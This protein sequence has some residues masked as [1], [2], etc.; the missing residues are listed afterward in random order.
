MN[1]SA[2]NL[3]RK[4]RTPVQRRQVVVSPLKP[5][6]AVRT[7][8]QESVV[9]LLVVSGVFLVAALSSYLAHHNHGALEPGSTN[10]TS[11]NIMGR[12]GAV[13]AERLILLLGWCSFVTVFWAFFL[14]RTIWVQ[15]WPVISRSLISVLVSSVGS[16]LVVI[17]SAV[18]VSVPFGHSGGGRL[19]SHIAYFLI[20]YVNEAG[21][22]LFSLA[23]LL[24]SL[25][26]STGVGSSR[27]AGVTTW[28]VGW[29]RVLV[30]DSVYLFFHLFSVTRRVTWNVCQR[31]IHGIMSFLRLIFQ[32]VFLLV[33]APVR[34]GRKI[35]Y[36]DTSLDQEDEVETDNDL[37]LPLFKRTQNGKEADQGKTFI[38]GEA[39]FASAPE[40][41][42]REEEIDEKINPEGSSEALKIVR[43]QN[44]TEERESKT[45]K[46]L[47]GLG[48]KKLNESYDPN[49][50]QKREAQLSFDAHSKLP[51]KNRI[52]ADKLPIRDFK[53]PPL[54][55]LVSGKSG[56]AVR[57]Q[58]AELV[59]NCRRLERTLLDFRI[60]GKVVEVHPGPVITLY[61]FEP[62]AG[63]KV[64][65]IVSLADDLALALKV[66]SVR[67]YAPV[68]G[69]GTVGIEV[70]NVHRE[71]VRLHDILDSKEFKE[72]E[73][74][75]MLALGKD[76]FGDPYAA[77]LGKMPHLLIAGATGSGKSV[78]I[79]SLLLSF[80]YRNTP[81]DMRLIL[82]DPK[83]L[84]LSIYEDIP[85]LKAPVVTNPKRARG[86][87]WWAV[88]E[89]EQ[90]YRMM[91]DFG[92]RD[93]ASF[94]RV[95][96]GRE[97]NNEKARSS[98][99]SSSREG[100]I[101]LQEKDVI[102]TSMLADQP[103][104]KVDSGEMITRD[105]QNGNPRAFQ[106]KLIEGESIQALPRIVI[107]IDELADLMLTVGRE[108]EELLTRLAQKARAAGIHLILATQRPSVNVITGL[109]KANFP[110]RI[111]FQV[112]SRIDARTVMD[113]SGAEKLLGQGDML[114]LAPGM[115]RVKRLHGAFV[116]D[117]EVQDA[118]QWIRDQGRPDYDPEI[119]KT[120]E[121]LN[122]SE[123]SDVFG[124]EEIADEY[125]ALYDQAVSLVKDKGQASTSL[126][127]RVFRIGYNRAARILDK[128]E[129]EGVV[130]P[131]DGAKPRQVY[132]LGRD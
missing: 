80:L 12:V 66:A 92:V 79:N 7:I 73:S 71:I 76:T 127:Q 26:I 9:L 98:F 49:A 101:E 25:E 3:A 102:A 61:Q 90:R 47:L 94:N 117:K 11:V 130:G 33:S 83:M 115:G 36:A 88:E 104:L 70:P 52:E 14:A 120:I 38:L 40:V 16:M 74:C 35:F 6:E 53:I 4:R 113:T 122:E 8:P 18:M 128:M 48:K 54:N 21:T 106:G 55:L 28:F 56:S 72:N 45:K 64:Q 59:R 69:K 22:L 43:R 119:E 132:T 108:I 2:H 15:G 31:F 27:F 103:L 91:K 10:V 112:A 39:G 100:I 1:Q 67:V 78:C 42:E 95:I 60:G 41:D 5:P 124:L 44:L 20:G 51:N 81:E 129:K 89:M 118:V 125:D 65:R 13:V 29:G 105:V 116:S 114:F 107:V 24:L 96:A 126:V 37:V 19:G 23:V 93:L 17:A 32:G 62:A 84:E 109:I 97:N 85:H 121:R 68:P 131:A 30:I 63:M 123:H 50:S 111:S 82:I 110:S 57:V 46:S 34:L 87:L 77:D 75:L 99:K 86:V 58:D